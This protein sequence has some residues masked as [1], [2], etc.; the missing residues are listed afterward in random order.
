M[1]HFFPTE[2]KGKFYKQFCCMGNQKI[3]DSKEVNQIVLEYTTHENK[4]V[5]FF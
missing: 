1:I 5:Y 2:L 3:F 4:L